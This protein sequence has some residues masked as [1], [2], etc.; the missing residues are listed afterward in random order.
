MV[1]GA[2]TQSRTSPS[3]K[4]SPFQAPAEM[5]LPLGTVKTGVEGIRVLTDHGKAA[6][7]P[8]QGHLHGHGARP[9]PESIPCPARTRIP[10]SRCWDPAK[11]PPPARRTSSPLSCSFP[12]ASHAGPGLS[13]IKSV[14]T[15]TRS[16]DA[17][18]KLPR[19]E[20]SPCEGHALP[21]ATR[22]DL[23]PGRLHTG[24]RVG[25][26]PWQPRGG[27]CSALGG[28]RPRAASWPAAPWPGGAAFLAAS[29]IKPH[30]GS[31]KSTLFPLWLRLHRCHPTQ[32]CQPS[33]AT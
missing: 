27:V 26:G 15:V 14:A 1:L 23:S 32:G 11:P 17:I 29:W 28:Q 20:P 7:R 21:W 30:L 10:Y 33:P 5:K 6:D 4:H 18:Y 2:V 3:P 24:S 8:Q 22:G 25:K 16:R 31:P 12:T 13:K 9:Q 19:E